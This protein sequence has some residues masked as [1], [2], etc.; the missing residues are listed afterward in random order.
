[1]A[2]AFVK[3]GP[4]PLSC[5]AF[6]PDGTNWLAGTMEGVLSFWNAS[7]LAKSME[8]MAHTR[9]VSAITYSPGGKQMVTASWDRSISLRL[10][11]KEGEARNLVGHQDI[12]AGCSFTSDGRRLLSW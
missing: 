10:V 6:T 8:F 12:V 4:K 5:C 9:P 1:D 7:E 11:G 2:I 3:V